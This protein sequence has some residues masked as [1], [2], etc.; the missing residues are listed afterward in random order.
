MCYHAESEPRS[1]GRDDRH[2]P[3]ERRPFNW[4]CGVSGRTLLC[5]S[6]GDRPPPA[7]ASAPACQCTTPLP[8]ADSRTVGTASCPSVGPGPSLP[9]SRCNL[10]PGPS[11]ERPLNGRANKQP[12]HPRPD[13]RSLRLT[14]TRAS[15]DSP[16]PRPCASTAGCHAHIRVGAKGPGMPL[17][18]MMDASGGEGGKGRRGLRIRPSLRTGAAPF[19]SAI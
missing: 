16:V 18:G 1:Q 6:Q 5:A 8:L 2:D 7:P 17:S 10:A 19:L 12:G 15:P 9:K 4:Q 3:E 14:P 13:R 11:I